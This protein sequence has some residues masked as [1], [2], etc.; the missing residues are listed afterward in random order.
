VI[1]TTPISSWQFGYH[2]RLK[3]LRHESTYKV[4]LRTGDPAKTHEQF[5]N[6]K[7]SNEE[8]IEYIAAHDQWR[9]DQKHAKGKE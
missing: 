3:T 8:V 4:N 7:M 2:D 5:K 1:I 9:Q 6:R